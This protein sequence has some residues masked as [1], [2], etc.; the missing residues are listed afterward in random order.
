MSKSSNPFSTLYNRYGWQYK[1][2][3]V[4]E[5]VPE[6]LAFKLVGE[7]TLVVLLAPA[8]YAFWEAAAAIIDAQT[9]GLMASQETLRQL[10]KSKEIVC[11][12]LMEQ[13]DGWVDLLKGYITPARVASE[14]VNVQCEILESAE[15]QMK[16]TLNTQMRNQINGVLSYIVDWMKETIKGNIIGSAG[17]A[18]LYKKLTQYRHDLVCLLAAMWEKLWKT[19]TTNV[20]ICKEI[21]DGY[22]I[23]GEPEYPGYK[24]KL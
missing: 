1:C 20:V 8:A 24:M 17:V 13:T 10:A 14:Y 22:V 12:K 11:G 4:G 5:T 7:S 15:V 9:N 23:G 18:V 21:S 2:D 3:G 16:K 19:V 6:Q